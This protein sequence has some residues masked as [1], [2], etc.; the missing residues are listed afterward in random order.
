MSEDAGG[1]L[2]A[3]LRDMG[4]AVS[5]VLRSS[6][7]RECSLTDDEYIMVGGFPNSCIPCP[8]QSLFLD[9]D[10]VRGMLE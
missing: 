10:L 7:P 6:L 1:R 8:M 5:V 9:S 2:V 3:I 4:A